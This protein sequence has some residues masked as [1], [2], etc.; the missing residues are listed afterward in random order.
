MYCPQ[1]RHEILALQSC[2][3]FGQVT[4]GDG[5]PIETSYKQ[6][7]LG[8]VPI[9]VKSEFCNLQGLNERQLNDMN[10]CDMDPGGY[11]IIN[12]TEKVIIAQERMASN[13]G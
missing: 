2:S 9:M 8:N 6:V 3:I 7:K 12:G 10:E 4:Y 5:E 13:N 1:T 11:F